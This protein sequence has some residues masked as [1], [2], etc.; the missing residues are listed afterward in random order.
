MDMGNIFDNT[1]YN[2]DFL[3]YNNIIINN[4]Q[5]PKVRSKSNEIMRINNKKKKN[6]KKH[7]N[8]FGY[9]AKNNAQNEENNLSK[10]IK[11]KETDYFEGKTKAE[12]E[13]RRMLVDYLKVQQGNEQNDNKHN[14]INNSYSL[15]T[16]LSKV[17]EPKKKTN[18]KNVKKFLNNMNDATKDKINMIKFLSKP[19]IMEINFMEQNYKFIF[20]LIPSSMSYIKG[21]ESYIFQWNDISSSK[22]VGGFDLLKVNSCY[23]NYKNNKNVFIET[24]D[25]INHRQYELLTKSSEIASLYVKSINY[26]S[27]LEKSKIYNKK[28]L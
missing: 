10:E 4:I 2:F 19:R 13:S 5:Q 26:L 1:H 7:K 12:N 11:V 18:L 28:F 8:S 17:E 16:N 25:G 22:A 6:K 27:R 23:I 15:P 14:N 3:K 24:F 9:E 21:I 20:M